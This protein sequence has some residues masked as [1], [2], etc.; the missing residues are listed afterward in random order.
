MAEQMEFIYI[1]LHLQ[2]LIYRRALKL[3]EGSRRGISNQAFY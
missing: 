2:L 1:S 3:F